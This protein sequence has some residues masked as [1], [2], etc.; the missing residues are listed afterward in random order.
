MS[1]RERLVYLMPDGLPRPRLRGWLHFWAFVVAVGLG[2]ALVLTAR[3]GTAT[4]TALVYA[5]A[6]AG[7][8]GASALYHRGRWRPGVREWLQRFDHSMIFVLIAGTYTPVCALVLPR[9]LGTVLLV[10]AWGGAAIGV[11]LQLLPRPTP[12]A[13]G[14][15]L[16]IA[17]GWVALLAMPALVRQIGWTPT[18]L[19]G[20]GGVLYTGGAVVYAR[21]RPDPAPTVFGFHEI[22]HACTIL[23]AALHYAVIAFWVLPLAVN[24]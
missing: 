14:V 23:A 8:F 10:V 18:L 12:R 19:V 16:Y 13:I 2:V 3:N 9:P 1:P 20:L 4:I 21:K 15:A 7:L 5:C 17:L 6:V 24:S 22:F 11:T